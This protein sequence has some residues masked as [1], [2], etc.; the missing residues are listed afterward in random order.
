MEIHKSS[1]DGIGADQRSTSPTKGDNITIV[2]DEMDGTAVADNGNVIDDGLQRGL[3]NRHLVS[4]KLPKVSKNSRIT[5]H[6][7]TRNP[8]S[9]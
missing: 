1:S 5:T 9:K 8:H 4:R 2:K 3:K 6:V 7:L